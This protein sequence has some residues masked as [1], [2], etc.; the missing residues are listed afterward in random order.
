MTLRT[1]R[2]LPRLRQ[3][4][5]YEALRRVLIRYLDGDDFRVTHIVRFGKPPPDYE[6]LSVSRPRTSLL[7]EDWKLFGLIPPDECPGP[8]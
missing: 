5:F 2:G 3:R 4:C 6:P 1:V 8:P 7:T